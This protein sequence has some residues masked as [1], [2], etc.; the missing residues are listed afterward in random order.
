MQK[1]RFLYLQQKLHEAAMGLHLIL[2]L[3]KDDEGSERKASALFKSQR[4]KKKKQKNKTV[5]VFFQ[6][7]LNAKSDSVSATWELY[8]N[9]RED[10]TLQAL[11]SYNI[12]SFSLVG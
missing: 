11:V 8:S 10:E 1:C 6:H 3:V 7:T 2:Q 12:Q 9:C 5:Q 4:E